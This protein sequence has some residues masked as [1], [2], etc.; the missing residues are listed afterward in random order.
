[1]E[2]YVNDMLVK[3]ISFE[4][5][6]KDLEKVFTIL[7][8]YRMK[9]NPKKCVFGMKLRKFLGFIVSKNGIEPNL[10]KLKALTDM[11]PHKNLK[12]VHM[13][14]GRITVLNRFI[15]KIADK[16]LPF[17]KSLYNITNFVWTKECHVAFEDLKN[18]LSFLQLQSKPNT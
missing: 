14:K 12:E 17:F 16:C 11:I 13:P 8:K 1:M 3:N 7:R 10:E 15:S 9:L 4:Q 18:Y 6:L 2:A 5:H